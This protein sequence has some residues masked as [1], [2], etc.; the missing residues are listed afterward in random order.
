[1]LVGLQLN[2][3]FC[4]VSE[5]LVLNGVTSGVAAA[6]SEVLSFVF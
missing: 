6:A 4:H 1:M 3:E 2:G 5:E